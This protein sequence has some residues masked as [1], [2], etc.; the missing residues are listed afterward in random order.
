MKKLRH[1]E[2]KT[3]AAV[4]TESQKEHP[5]NS[6]SCNTALCDYNEDY[7]TQVSKEIER[8]LAKDLSEVFNKT[9][10]QLLGALAKLDKFFS[11]F[12]SPVT[13]WNRSKTIP[14]L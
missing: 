7:I 13:F 14:E 10:S 11:D 12:T 1:T 3:M 8:R 6:Q 4:A 9:G 2:H 5:R